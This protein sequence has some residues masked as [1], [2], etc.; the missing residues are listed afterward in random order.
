MHILILGG[1]QFLGRHLVEAAQARGHTLTLFNRGRTNPSLF[2]DIEQIHGDRKESL[3]GL[4]GRKWDAVIDTSG[5]HP[6][7]VT[8]SAQALLDAVNRY[9]F[10]STISVYSDF[11]IA[12]QNEDAPLARL[13]NP[14]AAEVNGETYG[15]LK[16]H[17]EEVVQQTY[18]DRAT[19][20][21]PGLIVGP[22]DPTDRFTYW[23]V[24]ATRGGEILAPQSPQVPAQFIHA[25]DLADWTLHL[26]ESELS[27][28]YNTTGPDYP[29][30]LG[31]LLETCQEVA[32]VPSTL[33]WVT[34]EFLAEHQVA[35][36]AE[37]P[38]WVPPD[39]AG[40]LTV[41]C[42]RAHAAGLRHRPLAQTVAETVAWHKTLPTDHTPRAGLTPAREAELLA[43]WH[44][45]TVAIS[46]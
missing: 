16:T 41:D 21:R 30:D 11:T 34:P 20:V 36:F 13:D 15:P 45:R 22:H 27:G 42:T 43:A 24:R 32:S 39:M 25:S 26:L 7:T 31:E 29:L 12:N 2:P 28:V 3:A 9:L 46:T 6:T 37:L 14:A 19:I 35:P 33:T 4:G 44:S 38:L 5:Y 8:A 17:C 40:L 10:I 1:T 23:P 18:G